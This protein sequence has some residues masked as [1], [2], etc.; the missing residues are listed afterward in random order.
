MGTPS[1]TRTAPLILLSGPS[2]VG[3]TTLVERLITASDLPL[4]RAITATTR[5]PR[6]GER[7]EVD[8]HFWSL[9]RFTQAIDRHEMLEHAFVHQRDY[10]GT[11]LSEVEPYRQAGTGVILVI[12]VQGAEQVRA[13]YPGDHLAIFLTPP[14]FDDL[15]ARLRH[16]GESEAGI[17]NRL[18]TAELELTR[19]GE[20][21]KQ[22]TNADV[23]AAVRELEDLIRT[24]F[25]KR[26]LMRC[27]TS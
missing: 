3:K 12:D 10:Y 6:P 27:S 24:E 11:P 5:A 2:G 13:K 4:R 20:F 9:D 15:P 16:R 25:E 1:T 8:Y 14:T 7:P 22:V 21:D 17:A 19:A 26:G 23:H 18:K